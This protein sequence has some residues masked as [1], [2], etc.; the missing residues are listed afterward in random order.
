[1]LFVITTVLLSELYFYQKRR[2]CVREVKAVLED[3]VLALQ[4]NAVKFYIG[5]DDDDVN[6]D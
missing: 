5:D 4:H 3:A 2:E 6:V 1:M